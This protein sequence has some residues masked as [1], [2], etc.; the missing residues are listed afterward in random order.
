[1]MRCWRRAFALAGGWTDVEM[2]VDPKWEPKSFLPVTAFPVA[3]PTGSMELP[4]LP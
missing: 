3:F 4:N 1:M 2:A